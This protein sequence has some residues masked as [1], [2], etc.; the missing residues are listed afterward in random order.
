LACCSSPSTDC[1]ETKLSI[2]R[3]PNPATQRVRLWSAK[4]IQRCATKR[5]RKTKELKPRCLSFAF[6][7]V[8]S[9]VREPSRR[10][11]HL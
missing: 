8:C 2:L 11:E 3:K 5:C 6:E 10:A 7:L 9:F 4:L 1:G